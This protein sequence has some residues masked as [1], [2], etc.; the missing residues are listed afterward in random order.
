MAKKYNAPILLTYLDFYSEQEE[1][2]DRL[3]V[4]KAFIIGGTGVVSKSIEDTLSKKGIEYERI[5]GNDRYETSI[6]VANKIGS[7][8]GI[9][10]TTGSDYSDAL[11]VSSIAGKL[12]MPIILSQ[13]DGLEYAQNKFIS[14][15]NIPKTYVLGS[16]D[17]ISNIT[18]YTFP[19]AK[20][21]A[22]GNSRYDRNLD[23]I[24]TFAGYI[25]F[26]TIILASGADFP[27]ALSGTALAA[28]NG[29]PIILTGEYSY[30]G[31]TEK[32]N[33][34]FI[35]TLLGNEDTK[36]IYA[37]GLE[38]SI[39]EDDLNSIINSSKALNIVKSNITLSSS[40]RSG[41]MG[42]YSYDGSNYYRIALYA[43]NEPANAWLIGNYKYD[44][45]VD[46]KTLGIYKI[47]NDSDDITPLDGNN[48]ESV[49]DGEV[50]SDV[51]MFNGML[52]IPVFN[53]ILN[54]EQALD[55]IK[56]QIEL[57][58]NESIHIPFEESRWITTY[59]GDKCYGIVKDYNE[60]GDSDDRTELCEYLVNIST[61]QVTQCIQGQYTPI[62]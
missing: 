17:A 35:E 28:L 48:I 46:T 62:S 5:Y 37:L 8:N 26:S 27:D 24:N 44:F 57:E 25:D 23:I 33:D 60:T 20:R 58:A 4:K 31:Y 11:S 13:K 1:Q 55:L 61:E 2:L 12:Q 52:N 7:E 14:E 56:S 49:S 47:Y 15:N 21:I 6:A 41:N 9:I 10:V 3:G 19:N 30:S 43:Y 34:N 59:N 36:N 32:A 53:G 54:I 18:A 40:L 51:P 42:M 39:S 22:M 38:G 50:P 29:N 16:M 45:L